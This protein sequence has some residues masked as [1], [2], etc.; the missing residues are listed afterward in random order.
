[1]SEPTQKAFE[2]LWA[3]QRTEPPAKG[4][5]KWYSANLDGISRHRSTHVKL[6]YPA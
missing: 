3:L 6:N 4:A 2:Q 1:M 5:W